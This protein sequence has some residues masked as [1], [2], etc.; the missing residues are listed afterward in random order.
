MRSDEQEIAATLD[1]VADAFKAHKPKGTSKNFHFPKDLRKLAVSALSNDCSIVEVAN[2]ADVAPK[3]IRNWRDAC[4]KKQSTP[5]FKR[6]KVVAERV[7]APMSANTTVGVLE[8]PI[9]IT[10]QSGVVVELPAS[11][12]STEFLLRLCGLGVSQ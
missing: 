9:R 12:L 4:E 8:S 7:I 3:S 10:L 6:L 2:A 5:K 1:Q 11:E